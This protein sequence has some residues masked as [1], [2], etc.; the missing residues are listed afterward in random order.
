MLLNFHGPEFDYTGFAFNWKDE[1][2]KVFTSMSN[3]LWVCSGILPECEATSGCKA[4]P[5]W[6]HFAL[7]W[8]PVSGLS[9]YIDGKLA[10]TKAIGTSRGYKSNKNRDL[11]IDTSIRDFHIW[12]HV[13]SHSEVQEVFNSGRSLIHTGGGIRSCYTR[14]SYLFCGG[15][16][17]P[18]QACWNGVVKQVSWDVVKR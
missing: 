17:G 12:N 1:K 9:L 3:R 14:P 11:F 10:G 15:G 2:M 7:T 8:N 16:K 5:R 18:G 13:L 4:L 6:H